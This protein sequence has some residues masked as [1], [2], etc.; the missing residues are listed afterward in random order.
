MLYCTRCRNVFSEIQE[1]PCGEMRSIRPVTDLDLVLLHWADF[2]TARR[3]ER[4]LN[5][6]GIVWE[7]CEEG[8]A[9]DLQ[10]PGG[11]SKAQS[12]PNQRIFVRYG[13]LEA[14]KA[15]GAALKTVLAAQAEAEEEMSPGKRT[16]VRMVSGVLFFALVA[17]VVWGA[18]AFLAWLMA[19]FGG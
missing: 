13:D 3:L 8:A 1:N 16:L 4:R 14:A 11:E 9:S 17:L 2:E 19:L 5:E 7:A 18:D 12:K 10:T 6:E 15:C